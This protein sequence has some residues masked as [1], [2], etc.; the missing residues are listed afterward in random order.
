MHNDES[1][2][3]EFWDDDLQI[4]TIGDNT[5]TSIYK[6]TDLLTHF[7]ICSHTKST[8]SKCSRL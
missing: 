5:C 3:L 7:I 4:E 2:F 1:E 8:L 6:Q